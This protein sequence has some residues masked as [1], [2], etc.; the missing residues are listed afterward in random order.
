[1][2]DRW[3]EDGLQDVLETEGVG[4]IAFSPL[5]QGLLTGRYLNGIPEDS[6]AAKE[7]T[8]LKREQV[9]EAVLLKV[10]SLNDLAQARGQTLAQM[11]VA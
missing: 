11:A 5:A 4:S 3:I 8:F 10:R 9:S 6:R 2:F 7:N 1:M